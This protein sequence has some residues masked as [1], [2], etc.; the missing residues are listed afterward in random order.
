M[1]I[2]CIKPSKNPDHCVKMGSSCAVNDGCWNLPRSQSP[3]SFSEDHCIVGWNYFVCFTTF[4]RS[5]E[6][7]IF[8]DFK[9]EIPNSFEINSP[10]W[11]IYGLFGS[12]L[13]IQDHILDTPC[14]ILDTSD[15]ILFTF[16]HILLFTIDHILDTFDF[17]LHTSY[18][19]F[20]N[21]DHILNL[22]DSS[23]QILNISKQKAKNRTENNEIKSWWHS[24]VVW[25]TQCSVQNPDGARRRY[26]KATFL[27]MMMAKK[28]MCF[29]FAKPRDFYLRYSTEMRML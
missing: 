27:L 20:D 16:D 1:L 29:L 5:F 10:F 4:S 28:R 15:H 8:P 3:L 24:N 26:K 19:S 14:H 2:R 7:Y 12:H 17:I 9:W 21:S 13:D 23:D 22:S 6:V 25:H 11:S 18:S